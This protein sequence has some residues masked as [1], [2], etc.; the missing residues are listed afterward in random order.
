MATTQP[1]RGVR[2]LLF[3]PV[4]RVPGPLSFGVTVGEDGVIHDGVAMATL[5]RGYELILAGRDARDATFISSRACGVCGGAHATCAALA[6]EMAFGI[7]PPPMAIAARNL[8]SALECVQDHPLQLFVRSGPD[9]S[10]PT[11]RETSPDLWQQAER[12][13]APARAVHGFQSIAEIMSALAQPS[14]RL[15]LEA[16]E[17]ARGAAA[18][19]CVIGGKYPH[20]QTLA[21]GSVSSTIDTSDLNT[22][23]LRVSKLL[24]YSRRVVAIWDDLIDFFCEAEPRYRELGESPKNFIDFGQW[25]DPLAY[26]ATFENSPTWGDR[27]WAT[28]GAIVNGQL[29]ATALPEINAR[30]EEFVERSFY[31]EWS[32]AAAKLSDPMGNRLADNHPAAKQTIPQPGETNGRGKYSWCTA[33]RWARHPMETGAH[34]RL[35]TT[36][37]ANKLP[38]R[39]FIEPTGRGLKLAMPQGSLPAAV[40]EWRAPELWGTFERTRARAYGLAYAALVAYEHTLIALD[41]ARTGETQISAPLRIPKDARAGTGFWSGARGGLSHYLQTDGGVIQSY[42]ILAPSTWTMSPRD[43]FGAPGPCEQAVAS[44]PL[45]S[46]WS[47]DT[48]I[49]I[50]RTIRSFDPCMSCATH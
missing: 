40:L 6:A 29:V 27:R 5:F 26:D 37:L 4:S 18:A 24:D 41:F 39:R 38:H 32:G 34:A 47:R 44:G 9:Y 22:L 23:I 1:A 48:N 8:L 20:P 36:A 21:P 45:V 31:G 50:L 46:R 28:P 10:E 2:P 33:P 16:L 19:Y 30:V 13:S 11:V 3:D 15:Y 14:G 7:Q 17:M 25:D 42:Q 35:W 12:T 49:D 43:P